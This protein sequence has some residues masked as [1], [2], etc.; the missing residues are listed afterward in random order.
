MRLGDEAF[1]G[2]R[3]ILDVG[4]WLRPEPR[5]THVIDR[6]P[7]ETRGGEFSPARKEGERF[8][9]ETWR[10][11]DF[12]APDFRLPY[13]DK[14]FDLVLCGHTIEDL[15]TPLTLLK[16]MDRVGRAGVIECPSRLHEQTIGVRD[17]RSREAGHRHHY[18]IAESDGRVL[19]LYEK[20]GAFLSDRRAQVPLRRT[21]AMIGGAE[22]DGNII[23]HFWRSRLV[24]EMID[25]PASAEQARAFVDALRI[26]ER[27][28]CAD[29]A[30][31]ASRRLRFALGVKI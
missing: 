21:E 22:V 4:G 8:S 23:R 25:G 10:Q 1:A 31:R 26:S 2:C 3:T 9:K 5:A 19:R 20:A 11:A 30:L 24:F 13:P 27:E 6:L 15:A 12:L 14:F 7:W 18:W 28:R 17:R 16:E 29:A